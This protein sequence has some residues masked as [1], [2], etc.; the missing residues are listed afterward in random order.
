MVVFIVV[1]LLSHVWLFVTPWT[2]ACQASLS[3]TITQSLLKLLSVESVMPSNHLIFC[4]PH[5]PL[6]S[7]FPAS[8]CFPINQFITIGGQSNGASISASEL[9]KNILDW[10]PLGLIGLISLPSYKEII[11]KCL[12]FYY[13][14]LNKLPKNIV[15]WFSILICF[16][17]VN[18]I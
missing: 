6:P 9:P 4:H 18:F 3:F 17:R 12:L 5:L 16:T 8:G 10:F 11:E 7:I 1:Q 13:F 15:H 14:P 2:A